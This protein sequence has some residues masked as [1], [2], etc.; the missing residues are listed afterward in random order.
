M[1]ISH[2][3]LNLATGLLTVSLFHEDPDKGDF[4]IRDEA[5]RV[6]LHVLAEDTAYTLRMSPETTRWL[7][8]RLEAAIERVPVKG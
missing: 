2:T 5:C 7:I 8:D 6:S 3:Q 4:D 1:K